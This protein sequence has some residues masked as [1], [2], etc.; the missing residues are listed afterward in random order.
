MHHLLQVD[1]ILE[2]HQVG[3]QVQGT[4]DLLLGFFL[5]AAAEPVA[6]KPRKTPSACSRSPLLGLR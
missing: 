3:D 1:R 5:F 4:H 2:Y 6:A